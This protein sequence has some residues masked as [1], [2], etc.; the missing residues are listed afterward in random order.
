MST[1]DYSIVPILALKDN[2]IWMLLNQGKSAA[3]IVDP[4]EAA[5]VL[6]YLKQYRINLQGILITH[7]HWDHTDGIA[8]L[9]QT[10]PV[11]V[12]GSIVSRCPYISKW[13]A[14]DDIVTLEAWLPKI[15]A[16]A[17]PGHTLDHTAYAIGKALF[18]GDT[19]FG[20][21]C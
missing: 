20:A 7:H 5:P 6:E 14:D 2:Y 9:I 10:Y 12:V 15:R 21:G 16:L 4:G 11:E 19:L 13:V 8:D 18:T 1:Q 3:W 17:I